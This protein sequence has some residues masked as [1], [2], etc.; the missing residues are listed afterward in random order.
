MAIF[1]GSADPATRAAA[2]QWNADEQAFHRHRQRL[3]LAAQPPGGSNLRQKVLKLLD[4]PDDATD[5]Q[6]YA[7]A[8]E[9][10]DKRGDL[11]ATGSAGPSDTKRYASM[12]AE[13]TYRAAFGL[14]PQKVRPAP[15][16]NVIG[17]ALAREA[18]RLVACGEAPTLADGQRLAVRRDPS[19]LRR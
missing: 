4:L 10:V 11:R 13:D 7:A 14:P 12:S 6:L 1:V 18:R 9:V 5:Q 2:R 15:T 17:L 19:I 16:G 8:Y 3:G